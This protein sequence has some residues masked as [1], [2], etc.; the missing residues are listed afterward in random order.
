MPTVSARQTSINSSTGDSANTYSNEASNIR[1]STKGDTISLTSMDD[2]SSKNGRSNGKNDGHENPT[3]AAAAAAAMASSSSTT[4][5]DMESEQDD[6]VKEDEK[7]KDKKNRGRLSRREKYFRKIFASEIPDPKPKLIDYYLCAYQGDIL[8]QGKM[9]ITDRYLC[10]YSKIINYVTKHVYRWDQIERVTKERVA[11]IFPTAIRLRL[12]ESGKRVVYASFLSRDLAYDKIV[13]IWPHPSNNY[14][15]L[16]DDENRNSTRKRLKHNSCESVQISESD[17]VLEHCLN[18][19]NSTRRRGGSVS[20]RL[21]DEENTLVPLTNPSIERPRTKYS[22]INPKP[23]NQTNGNNNKNTRHSRC[24]KH[25]RDEDNTTTKRTRMASNRL[26]DISSSLQSSQTID[27]TL[28]VPEQP[29]SHS[30]SLPFVVSSASPSIKHIN[31]KGISANALNI[32]ISFINLIIQTLS[33]LLH[34]FHIY[35]TKITTFIFICVILVFMH[36]FYL[37]A[38]AYRLENR[39]QTLHNRWP[40][41]LMKNSFSSNSK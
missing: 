34:R 21:S 16:A 22:T 1:S 4:D 11:Y 36:S 35:P 27:Q 26:Q 17:E 39:L 6:P 18:D 13:S 32:A 33:S 5:S 25:E 24:T 29:I 15:I 38:L 8:L 12:K 37:I 19:P 7:N 40:S 14:N 2:G 9:F 23:S 30:K 3:A 10:F 28:S 41:S 31:N 20:P